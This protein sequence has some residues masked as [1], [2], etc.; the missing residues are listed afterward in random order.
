[1]ESNISQ[2]AG[3]FR[4]LA[5]MVY[6]SLIAV[7]IG[8][9]SALVFIALLTVALE[10]QLLSKQG[11]EHVS[12]LMQNNAFYKLSVQV[13]VLMWVCTFF[14]WFW[15]HGGQ[16]LGMRAW[17][18]RIYN[19]N[20]SEPVGYKRLI[21]RLVSSLLG[22]GTL[23]VLL[24]FK[25]KLALQDRLTNTEVLFLSAEENHHRAW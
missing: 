17:R 19:L 20:P 21:I 4:R 18:I 1:M 12:D 11:Y 24:D 25:N 8:M 13:W 10:T 15:K 3:F 14:L 5:A 7:A 9:L 6:D 22:L 23:L 2:R 16:T